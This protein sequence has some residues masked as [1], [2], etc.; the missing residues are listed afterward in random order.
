M[1]TTG[2]SKQQL[3]QLNEAMDLNQIGSPFLSSGITLPSE[4]LCELVKYWEVILE[5]HGADAGVKLV[6]N[7]KNRITLLKEQIMARD[8]LEATAK[9]KAKPSRV[10]KLLTPFKKTGHYVQEHW[11]GLT[12]AGLWISAIALRIAIAV[13]ESKQEKRYVTVQFEIID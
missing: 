3:I 5:L 6:Q 7:I 11:A 8:Q 10:D 2:L 13:A 1:K 12:L 9:A 4:V